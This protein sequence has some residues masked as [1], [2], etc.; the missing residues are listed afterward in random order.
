MNWPQEDTKGVRCPLS[1]IPS[2]SYRALYQKSQQYQPANRAF[3]FFF[4][5]KLPQTLQSPLH[6]FSFYI[7]NPLAAAKYCWEFSPQLLQD[8]ARCTWLLLREQ[9]D[10]LHLQG[11]VTV[12]AAIHWNV[13]LA[14]V[15][16]QGEFQHNKQVCQPWQQSSQISQHFANISS[17]YEI[18]NVCVIVFQIC[19]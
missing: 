11:H 14:S 13:T 7:M 17:L 15:S 5:L 16:N 19:I 4:L 18:I 12:S 10:N 1:P 9:R 2:V 6:T 3:S 8:W